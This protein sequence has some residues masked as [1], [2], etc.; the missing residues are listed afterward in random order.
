MFRLSWNLGASTSW[1]LQ[2]MSRPVMGL[3]Y[4]F[5]SWTYFW[6]ANWKTKDS[7]PNDSKAFLHSS[8][9]LI[10]SWIEFQ[11]I[12]TVPKYLECPTVSQELLP[13]IMSLF[14]LAFWPQIFKLAI[15]AFIYWDPASV[16]SSKDGCCSHENRWLIT[17]DVTTLNT[18]SSLVTEF[19]L[20]VMSSECRLFFFFSR[21][22]LKSFMWCLLC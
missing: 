2:G 21:N 19:W 14:C 13:I 5:I 11:S 10:S 6:L 3:L 17:T 15:L 12:R 8:L 4:L 18:P 20:T 16:C 22:K 9:L 1:N 7:A